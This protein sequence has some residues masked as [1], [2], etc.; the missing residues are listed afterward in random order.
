MKKHTCPAYR[1]RDWPSLTAPAIVWRGDIGQILL[2][3]RHARQL[4]LDEEEQFI[5]FAL[6]HAECPDAAD[7][8]EEALAPSLTLLRHLITLPSFPYGSLIFTGNT[9]LSLR[10]EWM[11]HMIRCA[12]SDLEKELCGEEK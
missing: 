10:L 4:L 8:V 9:P 3:L 11:D 12:R 2:A 1:F 6:E 7:S 5:C